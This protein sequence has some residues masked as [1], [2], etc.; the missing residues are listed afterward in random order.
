MKNLNVNTIITSKEISSGS[1]RIYSVL[2]KIIQNIYDINISEINSEIKEKI[3]K[4]L[5]IVNVQGD[6]PFIEKKVIEEMIDFFNNNK[7]KN[8]VITPTYKLKKDA[9]FNPNVVKLV[10]NHLNQ[11]IYFSRSPIPYLRGI[12]N[13]EWHKKFNF[14]GHVGI[15]G[16]RGDI[17]FNWNNYRKSNLE[18]VECLEQLRLIQEGVVFDTFKVEGDFLSVDTKLQLLEAIKIA[19]GKSL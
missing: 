1:E 13:N 17:L 3:L 16:Y 9:I 14:W 7:G 4:S 5:L 18:N 11:V 6:Q 15:Y 12:E 10:L 8:Q 2:D 19:K